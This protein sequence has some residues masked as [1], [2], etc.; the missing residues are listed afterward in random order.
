MFQGR[1]DRGWVSGLGVNS[2]PVLFWSFT[3][4]M[5]KPHLSQNFVIYPAKCISLPSINTTV[6]YYPLCLSLGTD[7][8]M[9][10]TIIVVVIGILET[11]VGLVKTTTTART[12]RV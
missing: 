12:V 4:L 1:M 2:E 10:E 5:H 8:V 3:T 7:I 11:V 9:M 6:I